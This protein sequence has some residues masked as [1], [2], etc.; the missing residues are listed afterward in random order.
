MSISKF[1][2]LYKTT[3][4][5]F[6][7]LLTSL[8]VVS[9]S[10]QA[11]SCGANIFG[12]GFEYGDVSDWSAQVGGAPVAAPPSVFRINSLALR[13]PHVFVSVDIFGCLDATDDLLLFDSI[14]DI[15]DATINTDD[16]QDGC[17]DSSLLLGFRPLETVAVGSETVDLRGGDC[18]TQN[19]C[20]PGNSSPGLR[21]GYSTAA[22]GLCLEPVAGT[23][24]GYSPSPATPAAPCLLSSLGDIEL[25]FIGGVP[26]NLQDAQLA[27]TFQGAPTDNLADGLIFGFLLESE[28]DAILLPADLPVVGGQTLSS[29]FP[30]GTGNCSGTDDRDTHETESGWWIYLDFSGSLISWPYL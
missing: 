5:V 25:A 6:P 29:L 15:I 24:S 10:A 14:N 4:L 20:G 1:L 13:D 22:M 28:A 9:S 23:T 12:N 11:Q 30:G 21:N 26:I 7:F 8:C 18:A 17:L 27:A 2:N 3:P 16:D 19:Q